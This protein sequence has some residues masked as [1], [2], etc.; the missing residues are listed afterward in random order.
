MEKFSIGQVGA[1]V[2]SYSV[3]NHRG[4]ASSHLICLSRFIVGWTTVMGGTPVVRTLIHR[5][6]VGELR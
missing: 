5:G 2:A 6:V 1:G 4:V 3:L